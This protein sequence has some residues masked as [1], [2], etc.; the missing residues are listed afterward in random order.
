ME[1]ERSY[2]WV[3]KWGRN[4]ST[5]ERAEIAEKELE[6]DEQCGNAEKVDE[7]VVLSAGFWVT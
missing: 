2:L 1:V 7:T 5:K 3:S 6:G 4:G